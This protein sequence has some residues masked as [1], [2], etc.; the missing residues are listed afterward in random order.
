MKILWKY[1]V[2]IYLPQLQVWQICCFHML[3]SADHCSG[4]VA[5]WRNMIAGLAGGWSWELVDRIV[6]WSEDEMAECNIQNWNKKKWI[7]LFKCNVC[8]HTYTGY[9]IVERF[10]IHRGFT[11]RERARN[12]NAI[13]LSFTRSISSLLRLMMVKHSLWST[14]DP[15]SLSEG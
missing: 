5:G 3:L 9:Y 13:L 15:P 8:T 1:Y 12:W 2:R 10:L 4:G 6:Y 7:D 11:N 14:N